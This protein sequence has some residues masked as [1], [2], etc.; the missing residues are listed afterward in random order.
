MKWLI[1]ALVAGMATGVLLIVVVVLLPPVVSDPA[2]SSRPSSPSVSTPSA[3]DVQT[4]TAVLPTTSPT[5]TGATTGVQVGQIAPDFALPSLDGKTVHLSDFGGHPVWINFWAS[6]CP[7]CR[8]EM[9]RLEGVYVTHAKDGL[10][11]LGVAVRD[12]PADAGAFAKEVGVTYPIVLDVPGKVG[13]QYHAVALP[14]QYWLDR[15]GI[16]RDWAFG[17]LP[18][19]QYDTALAKILPGGSAVP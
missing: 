7:P 15:D 9:P 13:D 11:I 6:W 1:G 14:V 2:T 8:D 4:A 10:V 5:S 3:G 17:E 19:D 16:V 12:S 18:L